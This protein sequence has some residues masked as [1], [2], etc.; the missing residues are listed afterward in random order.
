MCVGRKFLAIAALLLSSA[1]NAATFLVAINT[2]Q[3][4][5][6]NATLIFDFVDGGSP[7]N[8]V[9]VDSFS[10]NGVLG[11]AIVIGSV[12][13][14][15]DSKLVFQDAQFFNEFQQRMTLG[16]SLSFIVVSTDG[17]D[18]SSF[19][20]SF[21]L[22]L[23]DE[24]GASSLVGTSDPTGANTLARLD[25]AGAFENYAP[26]ILTIAPLA[27]PEPASRVLFVLPIAILLI[28]RKY[29]IKLLSTEA[30]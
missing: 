26:D 1:A 12:S 30:A 9:S 29:K 20:D 14:Q 6:M 2:P 8:T 19:P 10:F 18:A 21:S 5:G 27:V 11:A 25:L 16:S 23:L 28:L 24:L 7:D 4:A 15:I 13:G 17:S 3:Y 22:F